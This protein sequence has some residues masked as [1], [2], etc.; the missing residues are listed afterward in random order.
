MPLTF[1][2]AAAK[3]VAEHSDVRDA[4]LAYDAEVGPEADGVYRESA[5][6]DRL[7]SYE[8]SGN[9]VPEW[10]RAEMDRQALVRCVNAGATRDPVLGRAFLRRAGLLE[11]P[12]AVL[13]DPEVVEHAQN[14]QR[15]LASK[16]ARKVGPDDDELAAIFAKHAPPRSP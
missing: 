1:G 15:I 8:V 10:D 6:A 2:F 14:T 5:A 13:D 9:E 16:A 7:R 3:P 12:S 4:A 11:S